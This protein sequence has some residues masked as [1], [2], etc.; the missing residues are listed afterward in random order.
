MGRGG[1]T[2]SSLPCSLPLFPV[3]PDPGGEWCRPQHPRPGRLHGSRPRR[4][5][6]PQPLRQVPAHRGE[7]GT[8]APCRIGAQRAGGS[9]GARRAQVLLPTP[10]IARL[11]RQS[12]EHRVLSRDPSAD[13][14]C[15]QPDSGMSSP[16]T[17]AS[18]PQA[19]FE[20]GSPASTLSNYD[21]CN[22]SQ[23][24]TGEKRGGPHGAPTARECMG[25][26]AGGG[27]DTG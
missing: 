23:S 15:R 9:W 20:V 11:C 17:T 2:A 26:G 10:L 27:G 21:S 18:A 14:E 3:L 8:V 24:S 19:R 7:H 4:L 22:S 12:V 25:Q 1:S 13:G 16:N 6:R 5:Q